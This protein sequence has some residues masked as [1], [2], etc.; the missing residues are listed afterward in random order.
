MAAWQAAIQAVEDA[1]AASREAARLAYEHA[2][3]DARTTVGPAGDGKRATAQRDRDR[4]EREAQRVARRG[5]DEAYRGYQRASQDA[6]QA[7]VLAFERARAVHDGQA[8]QAAADL[9]GAQQQALDGW[10]AACRGAPEAA[11]VQEAYRL[12][13]TQAA[14]DCEHRKSDVLARMERDL[15]DAT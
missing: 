13:L 11:P 7:S 3:E 6:H 12:Q 10:A 9:D 5:L 15:A 4:A 8:R 1:R 14:A 2:Y